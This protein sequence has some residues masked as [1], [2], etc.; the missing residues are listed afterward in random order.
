M[1]FKTGRRKRVLVSFHNARDICI[2][3]ELLSF[4]FRLIGFLNQAAKNVRF[5]QVLYVGFRRRLCA[6]KCRRD[7]QDIII[8]YQLGFYQFAVCRPGLLFVRPVA[9]GHA[10]AQMQARRPYSRPSERRLLA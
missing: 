7:E 2:E 5:K 4:Q 8:A 9:R 3:G 10:I 1:K 6:R